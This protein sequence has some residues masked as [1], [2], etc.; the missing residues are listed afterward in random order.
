MY[1]LKDCF[2]EL[3]GSYEEVRKRL[4]SDKMIVKFLKKFIEDPS[5]ASLQEA[6]QNKDREQA[7]LAAHTLKGVCQN[8][9]MHDLYMQANQLS[10]L[11]RHEWDEQGVL[12]FEETVP[13]YERA[14]QAIEKI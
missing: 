10:D 9:G 8:L 14:I 4:P 3:G 13:V 12:V 6:I 2:K 7:F 1:T 11:L 5:F